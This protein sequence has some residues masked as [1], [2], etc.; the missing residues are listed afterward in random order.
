MPFTDLV[1]G[2]SSAFELFRHHG[3]A[4][5]NASNRRVGSVGCSE[6]RGRDG[7]WRKGCPQLKAAAAVMG[8]LKGGST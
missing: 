8:G 7:G 3:H 1:R 5:V 6:G 4:E 2:I